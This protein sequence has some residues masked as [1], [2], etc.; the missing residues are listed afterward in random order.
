MSEPV[1]PTSNIDQTSRREKGGLSAVLGA[2]LA[3]FLPGSMVFGYPGVLNGF[4]QNMFQT[5]RGSVGDIMFFLLAGAGLFMFLAGRWQ[6]KIG[7]RRLVTVGVLLCGLSMVL[8]MIGGSLPLLY[9]WAFMVG[10]GTSCIYVPCLTSVQRW[11]PNRRGLVSGTVSLAFG[12]SG[13]A[14]SPVFA[15]L[16]TSVG[17]VTMNI[18]V[19]A[20]MLVLSLIAAQF[21]NPPP[22]STLTSRQTT[23]GNRPGHSHLE[24][25][26]TLKQ[27]LRT[28]AFWL[29]WSVWGLQG[30]AGIAMVTLSTSLGRAR[31]LPLE[32]AVLI[33]TAFNLTNGFSR[34]FMGY[35]SDIL[36]RKL[37]MSLTF[38]IAALAYFALPF[39]SG[40]AST[41][42]L[43]ALVGVAL[44]T[45]FSVSAPMV[46]DCF[47]LLH[48]GNIFGLVFTS[49][50]LVAGLLGP[51][52]SGH[53]LDA[54]NGNFTVVFSYLGVISLISAGLVLR[55]SPPGIKDKR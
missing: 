53:I 1:S 13:A 34:F 38:L 51:S 4:W 7:F 31:G 9:L 42:V 22:V 52:L 18:L 3:I 25:S 16:L 20:F 24:R 2:S 12:L 54:T 46:S 50:G 28:S 29:L 26:L 33:L 11:F 23:Q 5:G 45:L 47:G 27:S 44:G 49:Y 32:S 43:A 6:E 36:G 39:T 37:T 17:Y 40:L 30:A 10:A 35:L 55:V 41:A 15:W 21:T 19:G 14:M 8:I 48:F